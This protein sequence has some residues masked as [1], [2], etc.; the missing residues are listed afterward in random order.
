MSVEDHDPECVITLRQVWA[1]IDRL[2]GDPSDLRWICAEDALIVEIHRHLTH[3]SQVELCGGVLID[4][5]LATE[6]DHA[7]LQ[8]DAELRIAVESDP[9]GVFV[10]ANPIELLGDFRTAGAQEQSNRDRG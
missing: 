2:L 7:G 8:P 9:L 10:R 6:V 5:K 3:G 1:E 4:V